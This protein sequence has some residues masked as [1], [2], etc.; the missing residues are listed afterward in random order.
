MPTF[1]I[2][3]FEGRS[4]DQKR[5]FVEAI[6]RITCETLDC[7]PGAV[8]IVLSEVK[9]EHWA[10]GGRLW[11]DARAPEPPGDADAPKQA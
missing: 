11:C 10:T 7:E 6:T 9:R 3:L 4:L 1:R 2:E 5:R 8:D